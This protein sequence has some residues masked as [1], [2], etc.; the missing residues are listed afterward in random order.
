MP[1]TTNRRAFGKSRINE[2][3]LQ[4]A[5]VLQAV[6]M[7]LHVFKTVDSIN[8]PP[9]GDCDTME[10]IE[11]SEEVNCTVGY[12]TKPVCDLRI[13]CGRPDAPFRI[14]DGVFADVPGI[15]RKLTL[16]DVVRRVRRIAHKQRTTEVVDQFADRQW[17]LFVARRLR[18]AN[19]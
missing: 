6:D 11:F 8:R 4:L 16:G 3:K 5:K 14:A 18:A 2:A 19:Q 17:D 1:T 10:L 9:V 12:D 13:L 7:N 15:Q